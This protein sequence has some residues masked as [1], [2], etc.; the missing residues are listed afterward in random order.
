MGS[1]AASALAPRLSADGCAPDTG[2]YTP[3]VDPPRFPGGAPIDPLGEALHF[4]RMDSTLYVR[5]EF[6]AP[7]GLEL[8]PI[9]GVL[10]FHF[11]VTGGCWLDVDGSERAA[12]TERRWLGPGDLCIVPHGEGHRLL[13]AATA[14]PAKLFEMP[15]DFLSD[16]YSVLRLSGGGAPTHLECG[17][18]KYEHPAARHLVSLLPTIMHVEAAQA[19]HPGWLASTLQ[20]MAAET[21]AM[22]PG[23][24][25][26]VTRLADL[27]VIEGIRAWI[28]RDPSAQRGWFGALR[29]AQIGRAIS[30]VHREPN[31]D[32][33]LGTLASAVAMSRSAFAARFSELVGEPPMQYLA[34]Y[35]MHLAMTQLEQGDV[36][37][38]DLAGQLGYQSEAAFSRAFKRYLGVPPGAVRRKATRQASSAFSRVS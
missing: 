11:V 38:A 3:R 28:E 21:R 10:M 12:R 25:T 33:S 6:T 17:A 8:P 35:R 15:H 23:S 2:A 19:R 5:S 9:D 13:S 20:V 34:R 29:D 14:R 24:E 37:I 27:L 31:R 26:V 30:F 4:L 7:W 36:R 22:R 32:W 16:R 1:R 18:V